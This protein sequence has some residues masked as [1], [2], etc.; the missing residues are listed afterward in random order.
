VPTVILW[1]KV[2][3]LAIQWKKN[4]IWGKSGGWEWIFRAGIGTG[5]MAVGIGW[6]RTGMLGYG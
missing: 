4:L 1:L 3:A 5:P 6:G 2:I